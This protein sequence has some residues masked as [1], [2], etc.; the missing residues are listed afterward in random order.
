M[1][2]C[3]EM[4][5][6]SSSF[7]ILIVCFVQFHY[8]RET[9]I[10]CFQTH[11]PESNLT[12]PSG[13]T[14]VCAPRTMPTL[15]V[16][17]WTF[18]YLRLKK[19]KLKPLSWWGYVSS[20][21]TGCWAPSAVFLHM[22]GIYILGGQNCPYQYLSKL[23]HIIYLKVILDHILESTFSWQ[24]W[25]SKSCKHL[26]LYTYC[27]QVSLTSI[28]SAVMITNVNSRPTALNAQSA[29]TIFLQELCCS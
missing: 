19:P 15:M 9:F 17:K 21:H 4:G 10:C 3:H 8:V 7:F 23:V 18:I 1:L 12:G 26:F 6:P 16:T 11:R 5:I 13:S 22:G 2:L 27:V 14:S 20:Q 24:C 28:T 25:E 29:V